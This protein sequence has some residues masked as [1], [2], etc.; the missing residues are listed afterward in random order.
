[1]DDFNS[2]L[3]S[4]DELTA[5]E[6]AKAAEVE[7]KPI[8]QDALDA[9]SANIDTYMDI[10]FCIDITGSMQPTIDTVKNFA[11]SLYDDLIPFMLK[12]AHREVKALRVKVIGF[13][14]FYADGKY[15]LEE[16]NFFKLPEQNQDFKN[17][18]SSLEAK[19]GGDDP[20]S[21]L[22]ALAL[23]MK[24][25]WVKITDLSTQRSRHVIVLFTDDAAHKFEEAESYTGT[26][27]PEGMPKSYKELLMAWNGQ[28][29]YESGMSMD[30]RAKRLIVFAPEESYPWSD[31]SEDFENAVFLSMAKADGGIDI[32]REAIINTIGGTI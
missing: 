25:D 9:G 7:E 16:S 20:E 2:L 14:D 30:K 1:M 19:G 6:E 22:E 13:R 10:V 31:M 27:Y 26:N 17:F 23:A 15:A 18:V 32:A 29:A 4:M 21:S 28:G 12:V 5:E 8:V 3:D 11:T 24:T